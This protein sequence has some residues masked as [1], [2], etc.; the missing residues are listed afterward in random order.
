MGRKK[1]ENPKGHNY[2][3]PCATCQKPCYGRLCRA[4]SFAAIPMTVRMGEK[5][6][7]LFRKPLDLR[8]VPTKRQGPR[9]VEWGS[10]ENGKFA[11]VITKPIP[12]TTSWWIEKD[13]PAA[14]QRELPR[15]LAAAV[16]GNQLPNIIE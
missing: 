8:R 9:N 5:N 16:S 14:L 1:L 15:M 11:V 12:P 10:G 4:C 7:G 13:F 2:Q 3:R 6:R